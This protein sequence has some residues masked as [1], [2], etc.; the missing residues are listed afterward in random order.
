VTFQALWERSTHAPL[1]T[2]DVQPRRFEG[3]NTIPAS[4][5]TVEVA[6]A[7]PGAHASPGLRVRRLELGLTP[8][9]RL[10]HLPLVLRR[11]MDQAGVYIVRDGRARLRWLRLGRQAGGDVPV[12]AG[13]DIGDSVVSAPDGLTDG[14]LVEAAK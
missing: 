3:T 8:P 5:S 10:D 14:R 4:V 2:A 7:V 11:R 13:L 12:L 9:L 6:G 1:V